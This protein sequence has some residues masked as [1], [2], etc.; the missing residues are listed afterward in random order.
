M[1]HPGYILVMCLITRTPGTNQ[2]LVKAGKAWPK[3]R[4]HPVESI[5][6]FPDLSPLPGPNPLPEG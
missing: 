2:E 4:K 1:D 5:S 6:A 3:S